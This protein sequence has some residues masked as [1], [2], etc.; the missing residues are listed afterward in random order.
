MAMLQ[1]YTPPANDSERRLEDAAR[2]VA[3][4]L[5]A[6]DREVPRDLL[7]RSQCVVVVPSLLRLALVAGGRYGRGFAVCRRDGAWSAPAGVRIEAASVGAQVGA[8]QADIVMLALGERGRAMLDEGR[9]TFGKN[10]TLVAGPI[11]RERLHASE[12]AM[13]ADMVVWSRSR[14]AFAGVLMMG[15]TLRGDATANRQLYG[16]GVSR[17]EILKGRVP[18][19]RAAALL[20]ELLSRYPQ[21]VGNETPPVAGGLP[22]RAAWASFRGG[23]QTDLYSVD[24]WNGDLFNLTRTPQANERYPAWSRDGHWLAFNSDRDGVHNLFVIDSAGRNLRQLTHEKAPVEA[25]MPSWTADGNWIYFSLV[26]GEQDPRMCRIRLDG[27]GFEVLG[28]G[29]DPAVSPDGQSVVYVKRVRSGQVLCLAEANGHNERRLT[30][31][32]N[33]LGGMHPAWNPD[34]SEIV[35]ADRVG[36]ALEL[37]RIAPDGSGRRQLTRLQAAATSP[38]FSPDGKSITFRLC[39]EAYWRDPESAARARAEQRPDK[40]PVWI[41]DADGG[42]PRVLELMHFH[43]AIDGS[44]VPLAPR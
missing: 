21:A 40:R 32:P 22:Y 34:G 15:G 35:F 33:P 38:A 12:V 2:V 31:A 13:N 7:E 42:N 3:A 1:T 44:R 19:P 6:G 17:A 11:Y 43:T 30:R 37:F 27:T 14:G 9:L 10:R 24:L 8:A 25:G 36:E 23:A 28:S 4:L 39:D 29:I 18:P 16:P 5:L 20:L 41:M 26:G